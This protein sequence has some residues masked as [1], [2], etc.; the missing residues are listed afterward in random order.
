MPWFWLLYINTLDIIAIFLTFRFGNC[1]FTVSL[2]ML[3]RFWYFFGLYCSYCFYFNTILPISVEDSV[4][5]K[6]V[7]MFLAELQ[8]STYNIFKKGKCNVITPHCYY[9][10]DH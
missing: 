10:K 2:L 5:K 4:I 8:S 3:L 9:W 6:I 1:S 7:W